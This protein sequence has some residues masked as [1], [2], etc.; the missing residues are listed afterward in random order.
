MAGYR[1]HLDLEE[2]QS[3]LGVLHCKAVGSTQAGQ[4]LA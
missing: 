1:S 2:Y 4:V 3:H